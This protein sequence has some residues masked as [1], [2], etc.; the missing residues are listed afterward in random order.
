MRKR[1]IR[2]MSKFTCATLIFLLPTFKYNSL[3]DLH[4]TTVTLTFILTLALT[5]T[6]T[7]ILTLTLGPT[8]TVGPPSP[9]SNSNPNLT[10]NPSS[11]RKALTLA[12]KLSYRP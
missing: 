3:L 9:N 12:Q 1:A 5:L 11:T 4:P 7:P 2:P 6:L 8:L 10:S